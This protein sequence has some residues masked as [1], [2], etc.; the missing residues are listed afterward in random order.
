MSLFLF[1]FFRPPNTHIKNDEKPFCYIFSIEKVSNFHVKIEFSSSASTCIHTQNFRIY[2]LGEFMANTF[3][4]SRA[5]FYYG[6]KKW[7]IVLIGSLFS[8]FFPLFSLGT[9][10]IHYQSHSQHLPPFYEKTTITTN[11][12]YTFQMRSGKT[13]ILEMDWMRPAAVNLIRNLF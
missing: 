11:F 1:L 12:I 9:F 2:R 5:H 3:T 7:F 6:S 4:F 8:L 13:I 10:T